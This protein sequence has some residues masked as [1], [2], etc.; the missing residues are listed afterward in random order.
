MGRHNKGQKSPPWP[1]AEDISH[2]AEIEYSPLERLLACLV[3]GHD[4]KFK[5][6]GNR[7]RD[8][9]KEI[10]GKVVN[11]IDEPDSNLSQNLF[12]ALVEKR[13]TLGD[14]DSEAEGGPQMESVLSDPKRYEEKSNFAIAKEFYEEG[15][16]QLDGFNRRLS[17]KY[18]KI[19]NEDRAGYED[20]L[21]RWAWDYDERAER[22]LF[23][24]LKI[25][26]DLLAKH[27]IAMMLDRPFWRLTGWREPQDN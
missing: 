17:A 18:G 7:I 2:K 6:R 26:A 9:H 13:R 20:A 1:G 27:G 4:T 21:Y 10:S 15:T 12:A 25:V 19:R 24:D 11:R 3:D 23:T 8:A 5:S 16:T 22:E 14:Q